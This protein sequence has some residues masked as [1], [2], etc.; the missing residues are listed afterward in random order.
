MQIASKGN[1]LNDG[2][3]QTIATVHVGRTEVNRELVQ[4]GLARW[5]R[6]QP[7]TGL[8]IW[9]EEARVEQ[10]GMWENVPPPKDWWLPPPMGQ[11]PGSGKAQ[12]G[13]S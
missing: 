5:D 13:K 12:S 3:G 1:N 9:E 2:K 7:E 11:K 10:R 6:R 8:R 4:Q